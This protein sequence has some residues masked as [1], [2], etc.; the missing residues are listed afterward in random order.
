MHTQKKFVINSDQG[1]TN[2]QIEC[3]DQYDEKIDNKKNVS[4]SSN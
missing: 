2:R 4:A 3:I 1:K